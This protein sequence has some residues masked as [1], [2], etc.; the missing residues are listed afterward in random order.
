MV[1]AIAVS[2]NG[3]VLEDIQR[4]L[5]RIRPFD[6]R[7]NCEILKAQTLRVSQAHSI[8]VTIKSECLPN[9][10]RRECRIAFKQAVIGP[11]RV[12]PIPLTLP[13]ANQAR[14]RG[15]TCG[16]GCDSYAIEQQVNSGR[17]A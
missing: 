6:P 7:F 2:E 11:N 14:W 15:N 1:T 8:I 12:D 13:P 17:G 5:V 4:R 3:S 10:P 9:Q 16:N